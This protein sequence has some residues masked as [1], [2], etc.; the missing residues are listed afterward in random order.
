MIAA[1]AHSGPVKKTETGGEYRVMVVDDSA[2]IRGQLVHALERDPSIEVVA[3]VANGD[4]A[5][6]KIAVCDVDVVVLDIE[7]PVMDGM[8][9]LPLLL[10]ARPQVKVI[11]ASTLTRLN[12]QVS[13]E[14]LAKGASDYIAKPTSSGA[15]ITA[16]D[17]KR[18]L[19]EKVKALAEKKIGSGRPAQADK[20]TKKASL[21][22]SPVT[23]RA[24]G[25]ARAN[26]FAIGSSTGG[27]QA[28]LKVL[29]TLKTS[30]KIP[31]LVTQHMPATFTTILAEHIGRASGMPSS[32]GV[33]GEVIENGHVY[34]APG[35]YHM[36]VEKDGLKRVLRLNKA[37]K[38]NFCRPSVDPMLRS[39]VETYG[40]NVLTLI[41]TGMGRDGRDGCKAVVDGGGTVVAQDEDSSVVWG[42]PGA[43][44]T[45]GLCSAVLPIEA[46]ASHIGKIIQGNV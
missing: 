5:V 18:D 20:E 22:K 7:M 10:R 4:L 33:D 30:V 13:L 36:F 15:I 44:A 19:V 16:A 9:A 2:T 35:D 42:M 28:L 17:F 25:K 3:S 27:P 11:M 29:S 38:E 6:K 21:Y 45:A 37:E 14:A 34:V 8:T 12:A 40:A 26:V 43:V 1:S 41:L 32:E 46:I 39:I 23:L 24:P 31:I